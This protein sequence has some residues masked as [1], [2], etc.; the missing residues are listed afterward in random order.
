MS[1]HLHPHPAPSSARLTTVPAAA[2][3]SHTGPSEES[4]LK[5]RSYHS[6]SQTFPGHLL[7]HRM[8]SRCNTGHSFAKASPCFHLISVLPYPLLP[9]AQCPP[10]CSPHSS[11]NTPHPW[12]FCTCS[13][14]PDVSAVCFL[15]S[16]RFLPKHHFRDAIPGSPPS[17]FNPWPPFTFLQNTITLAKSIIICLSTVS[18]L[19]SRPTTSRF[20]SVL[21][22]SLLS[23]L[24][25]ESLN[26]KYL[27]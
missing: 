23:D 11:Q 22:N 12:A 10:S 15:I 14:P 21:V 19:K 1:S 9:L 13:F 27:R 7:S 3:L 5:V 6:A 8:A 18:A 17:L 16:L 24:K 25:N 26:M 4:S 20:L 2:S